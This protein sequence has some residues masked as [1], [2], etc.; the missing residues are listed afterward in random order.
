[1]AQSAFE[2]F[3]HRENARKVELLQKNH[4]VSDALMGILDQLVTYANAK[5]VPFEDVELVGP[6][7][8]SHEDYFRVTFRV[9]KAR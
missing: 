9:R 1:M 3:L 2:V 7:S 5:G 8:F 4:D 6:E